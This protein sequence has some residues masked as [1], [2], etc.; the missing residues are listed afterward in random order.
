MYDVCSLLFLDLHVINT[1]PPSP[2]KKTKKQKNNNKKTKTKNKGMQGGAGG[3]T[4]LSGRRG[5]RTKSRDYSR[6][7]QTIADQG[8]L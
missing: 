7:R 6:P 4:G 2:Q 3:R 8:R 5:G 1:T